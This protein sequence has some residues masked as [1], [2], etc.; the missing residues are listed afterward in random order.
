MSECCRKCSKLMC[1]QR[2]KIEG[3]KDCI[4]YV[5]LEFREI[6]KKLDK[7]IGE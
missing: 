6:D 3:C 1:E 4:S 7:L 2:D 5:L